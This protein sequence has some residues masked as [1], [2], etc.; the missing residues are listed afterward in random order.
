VSPTAGTVNADLRV[1]VN[2]CDP[3]VAFSV[4]ML[5]HPERT[6]S[7]AVREL[8]ALEGELDAHGGMARHIDLVTL[9]ELCWVVEPWAAQYRDLALLGASEMAD[10]I[11]AIGERLD[12]YA[13][14]T[15]GDTSAAMAAT[16][17][18]IARHDRTWVISEDHPLGR[19]AAA[20]AGATTIISV[21]TGPQQGT[22]AIS[23]CT[24]DGAVDLND[25]WRTLNDLEG[26]APDDTWGGSDLVGGSPRDRGTTLDDATIVAAVA[27]NQ[28]R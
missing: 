25:V 26:C 12:A 4:W 19:C 2:D 1:C 18:T 20:A 28:R 5:Q 15:T 16:F 11:A 21:R 14:G 17:T 24:A 27:A 8:T 23:I 6:A 13:A 9:A 22:R 10:T 3:D 7:T